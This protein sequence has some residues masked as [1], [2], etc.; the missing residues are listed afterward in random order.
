[1][2]V[3]QPRL[4]ETHDDHDDQRFEQRA[5]EIPHRLFDGRGLIGNA[6]ELHAV[7]KLG[8]NP[9]DRVVDRL[10]EVH[11]VAIVCH[12]DAEHQ[13]LLAVVA[14]GVARR[15]LEPARRWS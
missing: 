8:L 3:R 10:A 7:R 6:L 12:D 4:S 9:A 5:L 14:D 2:P 11:D 1:M 15:V 13:H